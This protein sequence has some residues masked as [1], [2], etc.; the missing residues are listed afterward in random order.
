MNDVFE[1]LAQQNNQTN[2]DVVIA[3][4]DCSNSN[5]LCQDKFCRTMAKSSDKNL[6]P[7]QKCVFPVL[8][9]KKLVDKCFKRIDDANYFCATENADPVSMETRNEN[10]W[11]ICTKRCPKYVD[12]SSVIK[13]E[14]KLC[15]NHYRYENTMESAI[16]ACNA[17]DKCQHF[18]NKPCSDEGPFKL[19]NTQ[20]EPLKFDS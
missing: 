14:K 4:A 6:D 7:H 13:T 2:N 12:T 1:K 3:K 17:D 10:K 20:V 18:F 11:G 19:C 16:E 9:D 8:H 15:P 5:G